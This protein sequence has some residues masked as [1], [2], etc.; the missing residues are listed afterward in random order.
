MFV[1]AT[2]LWLYLEAPERVP[3]HDIMCSAT[4]TSVLPIVRAIHPAQ[5]L[6]TKKHSLYN[7]YHTKK[8][9]SFGEC[10]QIMVLGGTRKSPASC[11]QPPP[12][13]YPHHCQRAIYTLCSL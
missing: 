4:T 7:F 6:M 13:Q 5:A 11:A 1:G 10:K 9:S 2:R 3:H 8:I 12:P